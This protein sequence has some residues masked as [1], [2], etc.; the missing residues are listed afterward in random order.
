MV[1][2]ANCLRT[3]ENVSPL[4]FL[5]IFS[6]RPT[7]NPIMVV[8]S[9]RS[10]P[11]PPYDERYCARNVEGWP[12]NDTLYW[13]YFLVLPPACRQRISCSYVQNR[14]RSYGPGVCFSPF[15]FGSGT[16]LFGFGVGPLKSTIYFFF[17]NAMGFLKFYL[18]N[19]SPPRARARR[20]GGNAF[21][22]GRV[23]PGADR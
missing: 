18:F 22:P 4:I 16:A 5:K 1:F 21:G 19:P 10:T 7:A 23:G 14:N 12:K 15:N 13:R 2:V 20:K 9:S 17:R 3:N 11:P 6:P 8:H